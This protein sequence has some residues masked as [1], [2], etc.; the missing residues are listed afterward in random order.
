MAIGRVELLSEHSS[1]LSLTRTQGL[2]HWM[3]PGKLVAVQSC[4]SLS[5]KVVKA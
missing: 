1:D 3:Y 4:T 5:Y 2:V